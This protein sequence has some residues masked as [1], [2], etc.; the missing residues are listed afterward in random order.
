MRN[1]ELLLCCCSAKLFETIYG[2]ESRQSLSRERKSK[3]S[4]GFV[5]YPTLLSADS[6]QL[7][8]QYVKPS[9]LRPE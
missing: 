9:Y 3:S 2:R 7:L 4:L 1:I 6:S 8:G 5:D